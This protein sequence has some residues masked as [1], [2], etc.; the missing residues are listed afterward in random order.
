MVHTEKQF[1]DKFKLL[2]S[3]L[4]A[5]RMQHVI[6]GCPQF[7]DPYQLLFTNISIEEAEVYEPNVEQFIHMIVIKDE[8]F[9]NDL[10]E[11]FDIF[12]TAVFVLDTQK[13][14]VAFNKTKSSLDNL[15]LKVDHDNNVVF[16]EHD[17]KTINSTVC[18]RVISASLASDYFNIYVSGKIFIENEKCRWF[19]MAIEEPS[20]F[21]IDKYTA[22]DIKSNTA[23]DTII[24]KA[25]LIDGMST[26]STKE[27]MKKTNDV[28]MSFICEQ[29]PNAIKLNAFIDC[30]LVSV[31][32]VQPAM[33]WWIR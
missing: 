15:K 1:K 20:E 29:L 18:G 12:K 19:E 11:I 22:L 9:F 33:L 6:C 16:E 14:L 21:K 8:E 10:C 23:P 26:V 5:R 31:H 4:F 2:F 24:T 32:S 27:F 25:F 30:P 3:S 17:K 28:N 13:F 7:K